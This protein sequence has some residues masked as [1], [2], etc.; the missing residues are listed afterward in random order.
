MVQKGRHLMLD[1]AIVGGEVVTPDGP[2]M[3]DVGVTAGKISSLSAPGTLPPAERTVDAQGTVVIPGGIDP[4]IHTNSPLGT[5]GVLGRDVI[6]KAALYGGVTT[7]ID[8]AWPGSA[9]L[10]HSVDE[11]IESWDGTTYTDYGFHVVLSGDLSRALLAELP[12]LIESGFPSFKI[13][14]TNITPGNDGFRVPM[15]SL[16]DL[17]PVVARHGGIVNVHAEEEELVMHEYKKHI[18]DGQ[19]AL[20]YMTEVHTA[21]S[22]DLAFRHVLRLAEHVPGIALYFHH[23]TAKFGVDAL[24]EFQAKGVVAYGETLHVLALNTAERY[25]E[26]DGVKYHIYPSLKYQED[27]EALWSGVAARTIHTFGTDG[28]CTLWEEK[29]KGHRIDDA[30]GGVTGV[31]PKMALLYTEMIQNRGM[32]LKRYVEVTSENTAKIFGLY[33]KKGAI[34]VG[35]DAD[36]VIMD[37]ADRRVVRAANLHESDYLPW[38]GREVSAWPRHT[39][40]RGDLV[41]TRD[42]MTHGN[43]TGQLIR[44]HLSERVLHGDVVGA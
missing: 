41:V 42:E 43:C 20:E 19:T 1:L 13:F 15:G 24:A 7:V 26:P 40:L 25:K 17:F 27:V 33:P 29:N 11:L 5:E 8:F 38:E 34:M 6:T 35:S 21:L 28:V 9:G 10:Q 4:H 14:T 23:V 32:G 3:I 12:N 31:E 22:E 44:R 16:A 18:A 36:L 37:P 2:T 39:F 30:F